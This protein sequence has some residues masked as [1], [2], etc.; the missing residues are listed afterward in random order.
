[1]NQ[2]QLS[3][4][5]EVYN[6][7]SISQAARDLFISPQALS[8]TITSL[9]NELDI[10]LFI[11]KSN[12]ILPTNAANNLAIHAKHLL[13]EF[14]IIESKLFNQTDILKT[15]PIS[16]SFDVPQVLSADFF[17]HFY[18]KYSNIL[19]QLQEFPDN[20]IAEQLEN[21]DIELAILP[22]HLDPQKYIMEPLFSDHFCLVI[23]KNNPLAN[24]K[25]LSLA[26]L[27]CQSLVIK[28]LRSATGESIY[29]IFSKEKITP[30]IILETSD[31]HLIHQMAEKNIAI[32]ITLNYLA[33]K[34][35]SKQVITLPFA[36][37]EIK[38]TLYL[39]YK[40]DCILSHEAA[41]L[42]RELSDYCIL[43]SLLPNR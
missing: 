25:D 41:I 23:S 10:A 43:H 33:Q 24:K 32:G 38:K 29:N 5:L 19:I 20:T 35:N 7:K 15:L 1:M 28:N 22:G 42:R 31:A 9:E 6:R 18:S 21:N 37:N 14:E 26:D 30:K 36:P 8:K 39:T 27:D 2:R 3:Y 16:C 34:I 4:F 12:R 40:R 11:R 13:E 17:L